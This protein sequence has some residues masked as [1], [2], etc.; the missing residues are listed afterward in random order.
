MSK[1][2]RLHENNENFVSFDGSNV[3]CRKFKF[4]SMHT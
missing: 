2:G 1:S 4:A 3:T